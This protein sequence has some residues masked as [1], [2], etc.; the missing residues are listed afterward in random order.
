MA[1]RNLTSASPLYDATLQISVT[2]IFYAVQKWS[3]QRHAIL[4]SNLFHNLH[5]WRNDR[6]SER[7]KVVEN[8][9][10]KVEEKN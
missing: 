1:G 4:P 3:A 10:R 2:V 6:K 9:R 5:E 8:K 7:K